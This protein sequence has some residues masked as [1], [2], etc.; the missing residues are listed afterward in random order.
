M[1]AF[2]FVGPCERRPTISLQLAV[3][4]PFPPYTY[5]RIYHTATEYTQSH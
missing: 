2:P 3:A 5:V 1:H 4:F